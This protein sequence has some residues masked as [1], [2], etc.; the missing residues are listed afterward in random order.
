MIVAYVRYPASRKEYAYLVENGDGAFA[1]S[2]EDSL[3]LCRGNTASGPSFT[4]LEVSRVVETAVLPAIVTSKLVFFGDKGE[5]LSSPIV[6]R[7]DEK[8]AHST[9][10]EPLPTSVSADIGAPTTAAEK[11]VKIGIFQSLKNKIKEVLSW[12]LA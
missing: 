6:H 8:V 11:Q 1:P 7:C 10:A 12:L 4:R 3:L 9:C 2:P 5:C